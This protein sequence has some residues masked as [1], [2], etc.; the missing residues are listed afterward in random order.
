MLRTLLASIVAAAT[1]LLTSCAT[2][3]SCI[4]DLDRASFRVTVTKGACFGNCPVFDGTVYGDGTVEY[5]GR[6]HTELEGQWKGT[7]NAETLCRLRT[8]ID[9]NDVMT[10]KEN[11]VDTGVAD[12]PMSTITVEYRGTK[13]VIRWNMGTPANVR[14]LDQLLVQSTHENTTLKAVSQP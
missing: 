10:M 14:E 1:L 13:R 3:D 8:L 5:I 11:H 9:K 4:A 12:A 2:T 6:M 7:I